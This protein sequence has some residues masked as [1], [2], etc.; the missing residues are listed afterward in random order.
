MVAAA[1]FRR[2]QPSDR[3]EGVLRMN[4]IL[5]Q[6]LARVGLS[7]SQLPKEVITRP[8]QPGGGVAALSPPERREPARAAAIQ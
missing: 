2:H 4:E 8:S 1:D 3:L 5:P 6:V 7:Q